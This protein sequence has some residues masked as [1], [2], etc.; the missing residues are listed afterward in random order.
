MSAHLKALQLNSLITFLSTK[1][2]RGVNSVHHITNSI[3]SDKKVIKDETNL[4]W[5]LLW[6]DIFSRQT[7][8]Q[9]DRQT[10]GKDRYTKK[11]RTKEKMNMSSNLNPSIQ[12]R[13]SAQPTFTDNAI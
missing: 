12:L 13:L 9:P 8:S 2:K 6:L 10:G 11:Y 1:C 4:S 3:K 5:H 7:E